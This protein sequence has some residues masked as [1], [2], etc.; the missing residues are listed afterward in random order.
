MLQQ[1]PNAPRK[2][3]KARAAP[4][5]MSTAATGARKTVKSRVGGPDVVADPSANWNSDG[6]ATRKHKSKSRPTHGTLRA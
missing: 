5:A 6:N 3:T 1:A 2:A 4:N